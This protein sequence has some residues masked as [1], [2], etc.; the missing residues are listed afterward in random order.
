MGT[1]VQALAQDIRDWVET[2]NENPRPFTRHKSAEEVLDRL[3]GYCRSPNKQRALQ[4][5]R[6]LVRKA[7][8]THVGLVQRSSIRRYPPHS[9][10]R[11]RPQRCTSTRHRRA[12]A[13]LQGHL[14]WQRSYDDSDPDPALTR[15]QSASP[16]VGK[17]GQNHC[18]RGK[19]GQ[20]RDQQSGGGRG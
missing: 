1:S 20:V 13:D 12:H 5:D 17:V 7:H 16:S 11:P 10:G 14:G 15:C 8:S 18:P 2:W 19:G 6:T 3:A 4:P 9:L